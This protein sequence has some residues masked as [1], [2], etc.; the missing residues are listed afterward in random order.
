MQCENI[1]VCVFLSLCMRLTNEFGTRMKNTHMHI[2]I[3]LNEYGYAYGCM[4][5]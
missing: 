3:Q 1:R 2:K 5:T 4:H